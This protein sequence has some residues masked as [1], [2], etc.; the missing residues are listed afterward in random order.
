MKNLINNDE[1]EL[2]AKKFLEEN[3]NLNKFKHLMPDGFKVMFAG[4]ISYGQDFPSI[5]KAALI[6]KKTSNVKFIILGD[7]SEKKYLKNKIKELNLEDT[8]YYLGSFPMEEMVNFY[9]HA[10]MMLLT[11]RDE[12]IYSYTVPCKLQGYLASKKAVDSETK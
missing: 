5:I 10:N 6:L 3:I 12:L 2:A 8:I 4:N 1:Q 7:G 11:L 9:C